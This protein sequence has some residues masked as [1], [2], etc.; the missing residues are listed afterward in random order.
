[1]LVCCEESQCHITELEQLKFKYESTL[2]CLNEQHNNFQ[3]A[4][5]E[6]QDVKYKKKQIQQIMEKTQ[7]QLNTASKETH[8]TL[9]CIHSNL[10]HLIVTVVARDT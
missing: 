2:K 10:L 5:N 4:Q 7:Q 9:E 1:M 3:N 8:R 6:L